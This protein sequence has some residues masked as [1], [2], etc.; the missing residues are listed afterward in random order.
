MDEITDFLSA[1]TDAERTRDTA[2]LDAALTDDF[3]GVG[4]LG[5]GLPKPAWLARHQ[6]EL[7]YETFTV[8][9][10]TVRR[11]GSVAVVIGRQDAV[12]TFAGNPTPQVLRNTF[13][14]VESADGPGGWRLASLHMSFVAGTPGAPPL[15]GPPPPAAA[16]GLNSSVD[17]PLHPARDNIPGHHT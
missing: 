9:E 1:W 12:G 6:G 8:D 14:L 4:P 16:A 15:P 10:V 17:H 11:Y 3:V 7:R 2:W 13:V 5:F